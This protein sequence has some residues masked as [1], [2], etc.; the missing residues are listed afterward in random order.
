M[1]VLLIS[2]FFPP[3]TGGV[4]QHVRIASE[5]LHGQGFEVNVL[6]SEHPETSRVDDL[7]GV[8]VLRKLRFS[9]RTNSLFDA[10][11][12]VQESFKMAK[13]VGK[14]GRDFDIVHYHG[15]HDLFFYHVNLHAPFLA[16]VHGIFPACIMYSKKWCGKNPSPWCCT[17]CMINKRML[18]YPLSLQLMVYEQFYHDLMAL[19]LKRLDKV[20]SVSKYVQ[21]ALENAFHLSNLITIHNFVDIRE[22]ELATKKK[23]ELKKHLGISK[24][25]KVLVYSGRLI[26][27][28]GISVLLEAFK[29]MLSKRKDVMLVVVGDGPLRRLLLEAQVP[30]MLVLGNLPRELNLRLISQCDALVAPSIADA[31][32]TVI[33]EAMALGVPVVASEVGGITELMSEENG[34][35][36]K[37]GDHF[38][39]AEKML[40]ILDVDT[41]EFVRQN[42]K[43]VQG[44]SIE[45]LGP[46]LVEVYEKLINKY[47]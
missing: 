31:C 21:S 7:H 19:S 20:I 29:L 18:Y 6:T 14:Y 9:R 25:K 43:R 41:G 35:S 1:K 2:D 36:V 8:R 11:H 42:I 34:Y 26:S 3:S 22:I 40:A 4:E 28:K 23:F 15:T 13:I 5:Y 47:P 44:F 10:L 33:L 16:T 46:R 37:P 12:Y 38:D 17:L 32:P 24:K 45:V 39:L 30:N 27:D